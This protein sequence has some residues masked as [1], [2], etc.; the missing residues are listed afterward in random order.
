MYLSNTMLVS[1]RDTHADFATIYD[2]TAVEKV[3]DHPTLAAKD[4]QIG[5]K[6]HVEYTVNMWKGIPPYFVG[7]DERQ[8][9]ATTTYLKKLMFTVQASIWNH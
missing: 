9:M 2:Y 7:K 6:V 4:I 1:K 5:A 8:A 3:V